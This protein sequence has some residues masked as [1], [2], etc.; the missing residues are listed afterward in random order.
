MKCLKTGMS[1]FY[2]VWNR[3]PGRIGYPD[4]MVFV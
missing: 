4:V 3:L 1:G 2:R